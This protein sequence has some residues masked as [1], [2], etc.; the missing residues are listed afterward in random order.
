MPHNLHCDVQKQRVISET[1][2]PKQLVNDLSIG[3]PL[4]AAELTVHNGV[5]NCLRLYLKLTIINYQLQ[6]ANS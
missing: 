3:Q 1:L 4:V 5:E 2:S 6:I